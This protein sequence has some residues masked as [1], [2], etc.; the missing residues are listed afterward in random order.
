MKVLG[1]KELAI[2]EIKVVR[3]AR[4]CDHR[5]YFTESFRRS[6]LARYPELT[7]LAG[8]ELV[9]GNE[10]FSRAGTIRGMHFQ[11]NPYMG[12]LVRTVYGRMIDLV[13][14]IRKGSPTFG[15]MIAF[16]MPADPG[17]AHAE[18]IWVPPGFAHGNCFTA[19]T[20]IEYLCTGE[21]S[22]GCEAGISPLAVDVDWSLCETS[23]RTIFD[24]VASSAPIITDKDRGGLTV[25]A[26]SGDER[27]RQFVWRPQPAASR[28]A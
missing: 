13:L 23:L 26:W 17:A 20:V 10:S 22:Q 6:D 24:S 14:D 15:K 21:Y 18:W 8:T 16:D 12:K 9:Q 1:V 28:A 5:G 19:D 3:F 27:S 4:F 2:P 7:G 11:W 25:A